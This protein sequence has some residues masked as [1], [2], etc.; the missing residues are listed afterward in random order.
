VLMAP[1]G[2]VLLGEHR[3][4]VAVRPRACTGRRQP[5]VRYAG[6]APP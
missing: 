4:A 3:L 1:D 2:A 6:R 5:R